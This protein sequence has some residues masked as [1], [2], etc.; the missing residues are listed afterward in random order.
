VTGDRY[1]ASTTHPDA[2]VCGDCPPPT[3]QR[4][5]GRGAHDA[6]HDLTAEQAQR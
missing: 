3:G 1:T 2:W 4:I 5:T 6:W